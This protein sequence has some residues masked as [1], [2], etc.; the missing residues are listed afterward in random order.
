M[1]IDLTP[2]RTAPENCQWSLPAVDTADCFLA[3]ES[4]RAY[5]RKPE[6]AKQPNCDPKHI[7]SHGLLVRAMVFVWQ[8]ETE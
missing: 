5:S 2:L 7:P 4:D 6:M 3:G 1:N 8:T